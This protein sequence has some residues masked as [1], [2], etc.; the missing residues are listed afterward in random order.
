[1]D[2]LKVIDRED[3]VRD[4]YSKAILSVDVQKLNEHRQKKQFF[5][6]LLQQKE[7]IN[8]LKEEIGEIKDL[9]KQILKREN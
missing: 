2:K 1:M 6:D 3:L 9:L 8:S 5:K 7:Q 4:S